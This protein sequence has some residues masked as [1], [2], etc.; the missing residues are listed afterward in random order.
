M[1]EPKMLIV[2]SQSIHANDALERRE[3]KGCLQ[4]IA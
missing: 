4:K 2:L 3:A 1:S